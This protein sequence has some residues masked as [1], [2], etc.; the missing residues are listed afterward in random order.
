[1]QGEN[2][3]SPCVLLVPTCALMWLP[4]CKMPH[5]SPPLS[6]LPPQLGVYGAV[7][8]GDGV[9]YVAGGPNATTNGV[10][11]ACH[12]PACVCLASVCVCACIGLRQLHDLLM[13]NSM[14]TGCRCRFKATHPPPYP[15]LHVW[16]R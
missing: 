9:M 4:I 10:V 14:H 1:M 12:V 16:V 6:P 11:R 15:L 3:S 8:A 7:A 2:V 5:L 13:A